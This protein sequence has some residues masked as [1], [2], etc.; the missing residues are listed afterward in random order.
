MFA[1]T[2]TSLYAAHTVIIVLRSSGTLVGVL[3][4]PTITWFVTL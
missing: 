2:V 3:Q 4:T 1:A